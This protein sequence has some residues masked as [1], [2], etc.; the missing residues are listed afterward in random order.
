[1]NIKAVTVGILLALPFWASAKDVTLIYTNDLHAHVEPYKV[2]WIADGKRDVGGWANI[3]TL[4]K[5][6]K[7][8]SK[9][10]WFFDAGDYFTGPYI[11]S[12]TKGKAIIDI[13][14]TMPFDAVTIGNHE[15]D[16]GWD[17]TLLQ[18]SQAKFPV[19]Q[20]NIFYQNSSK[21]FWDKP[22]TIIEKDGVKIGVIGLHGVFAFNDTVSA[23]T[24]VGIEARDE[25]KWL[26]SYLDELKGKVD[27]TVLLVHEGTPARQ[28][29]MG[30]TDVRRALDKDIQTASQVKGLDI[31]ITGHAH[32]G[33]PEPIKVGNT[34]ILSTDSGGIDVGKLVLDYTQPHQFTI[35]NFELKTLYADEWKPDPQTK[36]V[37][38]GWNKK[39]DEE[40][41]QT[42]AQSPVEL[43]RA[44]GESASLGNLAADALL[45]AAG[46]DTQLAL[47]NSGGI[48]D[49]IPSGAITMGSIISAF[50]FPNELATMDLTG[51]QLRALME[52]SASLS[53]GVLQVSKGL[54]M[55]YDSS[56]PIGQR[57]VV[58]TLNGKPIE[59][60]TVYHIATQ[61]F[62]ADGGDGFTTFTE[63]KARNTTGGYNVSNAVIDYFKA[64]NIITDEQ[65]NDKRVADV[66]K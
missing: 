6:E 8:K 12:L 10:T 59:D 15:F 64:G 35:K 58:L 45:A 3:T 21:L 50:P 49:E 53:N 55:K 1:M 14:N 9:A 66:K 61:S 31:L 42:V 62:L 43:T 4:V 28:S 22:Y 54:E 47:T 23:A 57:V 7:S 33:T 30:G 19:V 41:Q 2:P 34:L 13:M 46:K 24:R 56:K 16:H 20:G 52:H 40:V 51:K 37:I 44:Y 18:L 36:R 63:G 11:S 60:A 39:L 65:L 29:S 32:V 17:N 38:D 27:L 26:Q 5:E 48:R 25:I